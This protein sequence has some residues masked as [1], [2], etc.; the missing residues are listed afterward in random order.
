MANNKITIYTDGAAQ[1]NPGKGGY[2]VVML[3][4]PY[5][6]ELSE[7]FRLT[8][9]NR[10]E[11]L[12]VIRGLETLKFE[13]CDVTVFS[14]SR[15]VVDAVTKGWVFGWE[16]KN[17]HE[18]KH[19]PL[20]A[21]P[22]GI[23]Q[24]RRT[25][26]VGERPQ[27]QPG[28]RTLRPACRSSGQQRQPGRGHGLYRTRREIA[29]GT[30]RSHQSATCFP[31]LLAG[32]IHGQNS[33]NPTNTAPLQRYVLRH[34]RNAIFLPCRNATLSAPRFPIRR[35]ASIQKGA[36]FSPSRFYKQSIYWQYLLQPNRFATVHRSF[37]PIS[38][39]VPQRIYFIARNIR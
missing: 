32:K 19:R 22:A 28:E 1:G 16:K 12:A 39:F 38:A 14:D 10:M 11:L 9:N 7:G 27:R 31:A 29:A 25:V 3:S 23:P 26:R 37:G 18:K 5:R 35:I 8:T 17:F 34:G 30:L 36:A 2:G 13:G 21:I 6:K 4:P 15:Y 24:T 20:A 33:R